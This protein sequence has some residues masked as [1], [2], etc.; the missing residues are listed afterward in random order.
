M[1]M[2]ISITVVLRAVGVTNAWLLNKPTNLVGRAT[3]RWGL[4][5]KV[6]REY[7]SM[8]ENLSPISKNT[9]DDV[10]NI[11]N[12]ILKVSATITSWNTHHPSPTEIFEV[13]C[14]LDDCADEVA[15]LVVENK[16]PQSQIENLR[17]QLSV[18]I[19]RR[20][21]LEKQVS[22]A[23]ERRERLDK[24]VRAEIERRERLEKDVCDLKL[25]SSDLKLAISILKTREKESKTLLKLYDLCHM[26]NYYS[27]IP[28]VK[29]AGFNS[30]QEF[31]SKYLENEACVEDGDMTEDDFNLWLK[32]VRDALSGIDIGQ[33][34][35]ACQVFHAIDV[36]LRSK[37]SQ[38]KFL[39]SCNSFD[40]GSH[41]E[42]ASRLIE[43][44][45][46]V[47]LKRMTVMAEHSF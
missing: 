4:G 14:Q 16:S 6:H 26:F 46:T 33:V 7:F 1:R 17:K 9:I 18:E 34:I 32:P 15:A 27:T 29:A 45:S 41:N 47:D 39:L 20:E 43:H 2:L 30:Y 12:K 36:D 5:A 13:T 40:F 21:R 42:I 28:A 25:A 24:Q 31:V 10:E 23:I 44:L 8:K 22:D 35:S 11:S 37:V 3:G 19:Q 38:E